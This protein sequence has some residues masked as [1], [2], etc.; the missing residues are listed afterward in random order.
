M[1][2]AVIAYGFVMKSERIF[3]DPISAL[4]LSTG[5]TTG[6][7]LLQGFSSAFDS[8]NQ[9]SFNRQQAEQER[10]LRAQELE[11]FEKEQSRAESRIIAVLAAQ[12]EDLTAG[13]PLALLEAQASEGAIGRTRIITQSEAREAGFE[14]RA[15]NFITRGIFQ[16]AGG[17]LT[18]A[19]GAARGQQS[20]LRVTTTRTLTGGT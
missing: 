3:Y 20:L 1:H 6:T 8:F 4:S 14:S 2:R 7:R 10:I 16:A 19:T 18:G 9:A 13:T 12:G 17:I 11:D 15:D 5:V